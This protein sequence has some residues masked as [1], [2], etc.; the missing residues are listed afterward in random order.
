[1]FNRPKPR[2]KS[3]F[4]V[5]L[6]IVIFDFGSKIL[7]KEFIPPMDW[8]HP[9]YPYGGIGVFEDFLGINFSLN[10]VENRGMAWGLFASYFDYLLLVRSLLVF[11]LLIYAVFFNKDTKKQLPLTLIISGAIGNILD[12]LLFGFVIDFIHFN[13]WG[14]SFPVFN[15]ADSSV[16]IGAFWLMIQ[17]SVQKGK[18]PIPGAIKLDLP[19]PPGSFKGD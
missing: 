8:L 12:C 16:C 17:M 14:Y 11:A 15:I 4:F 2:K 5:L 7:A 3:F 19:K 18:R 9:T 6:A 10:Y 13:F 1:M